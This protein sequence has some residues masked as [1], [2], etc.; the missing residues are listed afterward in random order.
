MPR[1][2]ILIPLLIALP[3]FVLAVITHRTELRKRAEESST[4]C[5]NRVIAHEESF[6]WPDGCRGAHVEP[7]SDVVCPQ[8]ITPLNDEELAGYTEWVNNGR[9]FLDNCGMPTPTESPQAT[10]EATPSPTLLLTPTVAPQ[11]MRLRVT[12]GGASGAA[13]EGATISVKFQRRNAPTLQLPVPLTLTSADNNVYEASVVLNNPM[14]AG[15]AFT[16]IIKGEKHIAVKFCRQAG[17]TGPCEDDEFITVPNPIP[18]TYNFDLTGVPLPPGDVWPQ[19]GKA[20]GDDFERIMTLLN[21]S[22]DSLTAE[23]KLIADLDYN[24]CINVRD[25]FLMRQTLQTRYDEQ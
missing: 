24:G 17:Q 25:A 9:P 14:P 19:D 2:I 6:A 10:P 20:D 11:T 18:L 12:L 7:N 15:T 21:K 22:C 13:A 5:Y 3:F 16:L 23:D 4:P 8:V 1:F